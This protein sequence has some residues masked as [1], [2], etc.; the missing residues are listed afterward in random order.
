MQGAGRAGPG[1]GHPR[2]HRPVPRRDHRRDGRADLRR[3]CS[4]ERKKRSRA[5][6]SGTTGNRIGCTFTPASK[7]AAAIRAAATELPRMTGTMPS[8][9][10]SPVSK[11]AS[12][13]RPQ[14]QPGIGL[15]LRHP[16]RLGLQDAEQFQRRG[17][18]RRAPARP[19]RRSPAPYAAAG[20]PAAACRR[21]SRRR[22]D[23]VFDSV[24]IQI[25]TPPGSTPHCS[26]MPRPVAPST[27]S[28][29]AS[30]TISSASWRRAMSAKRGQVGQV[31]IHAVVA[32][33][34]P[35]ARGHAGGDA[36]RARA[37]P[38]ASR[39]GEG[40]APRA[41]Q[42]GALGDA[43]VDQ[44][45]MQHQVA[46]ADQLADDRDI[47]RMAA[48]EGEA[49]LRC[50]MRGQRR[51]QRAHAPAARPRRGGRRRRRRRAGR[52]PPWPPPRSRGSPFSP[53]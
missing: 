13:A 27:P 36:R 7:A 19:N 24:P 35:A 20:P 3:V 43:V 49:G 53:R 42:P 6:R 12:R 15:Q 38:P 30:S 46:R 23:S 21:C 32:L 28:E 34:R 25:S 2:R 10:E 47:R 41:R 52:S 9:A 18:Q 44:P 26:A 45:V 22:P 5:E 16:P 39:Y 17:G 11:L 40:D 51:F 8:P 37:P 4:A 48:D 1:L 33:E 29:C 14:E 50:V 31:A